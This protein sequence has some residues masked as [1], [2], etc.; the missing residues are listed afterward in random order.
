MDKDY[1]AVNDEELEE[2]NGGM[3]VVVEETEEEA[4]WWETIVNAFFGI[5][6]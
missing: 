3:K 5:R 1:K 6:G 2:I 4:G